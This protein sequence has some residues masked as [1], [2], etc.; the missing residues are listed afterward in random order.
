MFGLQLETLLMGN[1]SK[2]SFHITGKLNFCVYSLRQLS[3]RKA[4]STKMKKGEE[5]P[6]SSLVWWRMTSRWNRRPL[7]SPSNPSRR[8]KCGELPGKRRPERPRRPTHPRGQRK[9]GRE[10]ATFAPTARQGQA[11]G[12][13]G[14]QGWGPAP[15]PDPQGLLTPPVASKKAI[16]QGPRPLCLQGN[17]G[18]LPSTPFFLPQA[19]SPHTAVKSIHSG[20]DGPPGQPAPTLAPPR[21][22]SGPRGRTDWLAL[23]APGKETPG[24]WP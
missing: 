10:R 22:P 11:A 6:S 1:W 12:T 5:M 24:D 9:G 4:S 8:K 14:T 3:K 18:P 17:R 15:F 20:S 7:A 21:P 16:C 23:A 2:L 13:P 19:V